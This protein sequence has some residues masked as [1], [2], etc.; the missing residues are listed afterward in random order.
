[1]TER[2]ALATG[3]LSAEELA[4]NFDDIKPPLDHRQVLVESSRCHFCFDAPCIEACPTGIDIPSFIRK[5]GTGNLKG[6]AIDI[7]EENIMGGICARACPTEILCEDAC[8]RNAGERKPVKIGLLQRHA[9]DWLFEK[10]IQPFRRAPDSGKRVAIV[11]GGPAGLSCAHRLALLGHAVTIFEARGKLGGLNEFGIA[12]YKVPHDFA[13]R[14]IAFILAIGGIEQRTNQALGRDVAL[15]TLR[16]EYDAVFLAL[17]LAGT[18]A[19]AIAGESLAGVEDAVAYIER[20]RQATDPTRLPVGRRVVVIGGGNT[21]IDVAVQSK[22]LGAEEVTLVY[23][24]GIE[25]MSATWHE[26]EFAQTDNVVIRPW[27]RPLRLIGA[28][29]RVAAVECEHT[30][31]DAAGRLAGTGDRF[32][33]DADMVFKAIGQIPV[34]DPLR[35]GGSDIL[36]LRDGRIAVNDTRETSLSGIWAGGDCIARPD[37]TV[38]AVQDGKIAAQAID[39]R[40]RMAA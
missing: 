14:E 7:L 10:G 21:A 29:G 34:P 22:R 6:A 38:Q 26:R 1:M 36:E 15:A 39:R 8:V 19:L 4:R 30:Q 23:R 17:G 18:N 25:Q 9:T 35:D 37:L 28:D 33:L 20:I 12:A 3:V 32:T 40:L 5:I 13:Q 11:G 2:P 27:S 31:L 24:R 16:Q